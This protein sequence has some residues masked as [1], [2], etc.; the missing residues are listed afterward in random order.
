VRCLSFPLAVIFLAAPLFA[1]SNPVPSVNQPLVPSN[2]APGA[3]AFTLRVN[4]TGFVPGAVVK[5]NGI[6]LSTRF[7]NRSQLRAT[8]PAARATKAGTTSITVNNPAPGGG[9]SNVVF[10]TVSLPSASLTFATTI[11]NVGLTPASIV[12]GDF[13]N[14]GK[15]D[16]AVE[17]LTQPDSCY[18]F[19]GVGTIQLLLGNGA[20]KFS[21][22]SQTCLPNDLGTMGLPELLAADF[23]NDGKLD[24]A[25]EWFSFG[26]SAISVYLGAG[27]GTLAFQSSVTQSDVEAALGTAVADFNAD[28]HLDLVFPSNDSAFPGI[29][30][31]FGDGKGNFAFGA[32]GPPVYGT[33]VVSG[34]FNG[35]GILDLA[36]LGIDEGTDVGPP[37]ILLG[38]GGGS[39]VDAPTQPV[40]TLVSAVSATTGDFNGDGILDL[41][42]ADSGSTALTVL[43]GNGNGTFT[44]KTGEPDAGQTTT[45]ITTADVN[46]DGKLDLVQISSANTVLIYLGNGDGTFQTA[47]ETAA[48]NGATQLAVGDFNG[49]GRLDLAITNSAD[50]TVSLLIQSPAAIVSSSLLRFG[51][52]AV[53][54]T[55]VPRHVTLT[56]SGSAALQLTSVTASGNFAE[57]NNCKAILPIGQS[58]DINVVFKPTTTGL[59]A[60][61]ITI[62]DNASDSPQVIHL[63]GTGD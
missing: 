50:N 55:S 24:A 37:L 16:L 63:D 31:Y 60:G 22:A 42:F 36:V 12:A 15:T 43:L 39:F 5:W 13:N 25:A 10:F 53:G 58:C 14:D 21:T 8:V 41:A 1:A 29:F 11:L 59:K 48:G 26:A 57:T 7:V 49:D 56:N 35:D 2:V 47:A 32:S 18:Q 28:G 34:D 44:Q 38:A 62:T 33:S 3:A 20:G 51:K 54:T 45:F 46:G 23:N 27:N 19:N 4:G 6:P 61:N 9:T 17:N 52:Q 40:T 30:D